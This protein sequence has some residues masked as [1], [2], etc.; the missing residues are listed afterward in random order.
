MIRGP[1]EDLQAPNYLVPVQVGSCV[2]CGVM[3]G[4]V[5]CE[6]YALKHYNLSF[7]L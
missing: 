5:V 1:L 6:G 2:M 7:E 4:C 3:V